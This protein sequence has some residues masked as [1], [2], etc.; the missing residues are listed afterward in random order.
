MASL[1]KQVTAQ[2]ISLMAGRKARG[3]APL[4][5]TRTRNRK[6]KGQVT[7]GK[8]KKASFQPRNDGQGNQIISDKIGHA[9]AK[10]NK[11]MEDKIR[12]ALQRQNTQLF[13]SSGQLIVQNNRTDYQAWEIGNVTDIQTMVT[14]AASQE[15]NINGDDGSN[16]HVG[17]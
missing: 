4:S 7:H 1:V 3:K 16:I 12:N 5:K 8:K 13:Q 2:V 17:F 6:A 10:L 9:P 14:N 11:K 15:Q